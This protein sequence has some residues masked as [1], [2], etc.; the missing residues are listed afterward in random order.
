MTRPV[1]DN[2]SEDLAA[3]QSEIANKIKNLVANEFILESEWG[4]RQTV[5][6]ENQRVFPRCSPNQSLLSHGFGFM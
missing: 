4:I 6:G 1:R 2:I 5:A 3:G